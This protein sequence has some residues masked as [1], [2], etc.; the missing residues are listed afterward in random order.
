MQSLSFTFSSNKNKI[1]FSG[2]K[3]ISSLY[4]ETQLS[5]KML[6]LVKQEIKG[7]NPFFS[8]LS[9][10]NYLTFAI[11]K[12]K[13]FSFQIL[14]F[15]KKTNLRSFYDQ[16]ERM[17]INIWNK[18][19][20]YNLWIPIQTHQQAFILTTVLRSLCGCVGIKASLIELLLL[21]HFLFLFC[22]SKAK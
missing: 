2:R 3:M 4:W 21:K 7:K 6:E 15:K 14:C 16:T 17:S 20:Q 9:W 5:G 8:A 19:S 13:T 12:I 1:G 11:F 18:E 10:A 22:E